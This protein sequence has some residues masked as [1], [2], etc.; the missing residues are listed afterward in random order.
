MTRW[1]Q[2]CEVFLLIIIAYLRVVLDCIFYI[3]IYY[4]SL[5]T[6]GMSHLKILLWWRKTLPFPYCGLNLAHRVGRLWS[7][8]QFRHLD[9]GCVQTVLFWV[10]RHH[11]FLYIDSTVSGEVSASIFIVYVTSTLTWSQLSLSRKHN[12]NI[13]FVWRIGQ[14]FRL[15]LLCKMEYKISYGSTSTLNFVLVMRRLCRKHYVF[16]SVHP[17]KR[18]PEKS[19]Q[20]GLSEAIN[21]DSCRI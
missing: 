15:G 4:C 5:N 7:S 6:T 10:S 12:M 3:F 14:N 17:D 20:M 18:Y 21:L 9:S 1:R 19:A 13:I 2:W 11:V 8:M 16:Y